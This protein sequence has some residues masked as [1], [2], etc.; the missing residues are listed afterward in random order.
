MSNLS[1]FIG[2]DPQG[3]VKMNASAA[4]TAGDVMVN[5]DTGKPT[6]LSTALGLAF[7]TNATAGPQ[8]IKAATG[9]EGTTTGY[10]HS[11]ST[12]QRTL[13][14]LG[15]GDFAMV[16]SGNGTTADNSLK[17][18]VTNKLGAN[19]CARI[20]VSADT[21]IQ[22]Y[23]IAKLNSTQMVV[24][25][26]ASGQPLKFSILNNDGTI[27]V[28][29]TTVSS[30]NTSN[31]SYWNMAVTASGQVV[32]AYYKVTSG[33][34]NF[35]RYNASGALQG[36]ETTVE[37]SATPT[38]IA[39]LGCANG[40]FVVSYYRSAAT[41]AYKFARYNASGV[42]QGALVTLVTTGSPLSGGDYTNGLIELVNGNIVFATPGA[43]DNSPDVHIYTSANVF[44]KTTEY[45]VGAINPNEV[46]CL[47]QSS[48]GFVLM[49]RKYIGTG[50]G[51]W[52]YRYT[53]AGVAIVEQVSFGALATGDNA[54]TSGSGIS[55]ISLGSTGFAVLGCY[56]HSSPAYELRLATVN[57]YGVLIGSEIV[58]R[59]AGSPVIYANNIAGDTT[60]IAVAYKTQD[61]TYQTAGFYNVVRKSVLGVA[62]NS[63]AADAQVLVATKG[64]YT[65]N[66]SV[67]AGG[68]FDGRSAAVPG[69][70]G[71][72]AGNSAVLFGLQP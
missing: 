34:F 32:F 36:A 24:A 35:S 1:D 18:R 55:A 6:V 69:T 50:A 4:F 62:Q 66:Q 2:A 45:G 58:L 13:C 72:V 23:R 63:G 54:S 15:N 52:F 11:L 46:P 20:D 30:L 44:V 22:S 57:N 48:D 38:Y 43:A 65:I 31:A 17:V 68:V 61:T 67:G 71:M 41:S 51:M 14:I 16:Y 47:V 53:S 26:A 27:A 64:S 21:S 39:V 37:A 60:S 33:N 29:A 70:R 7:E 49:A 19:Q 9:V 10:G 5:N 25:W 40:D 59:T 42:I 3:I 8:A 12:N 28:A 56:Y